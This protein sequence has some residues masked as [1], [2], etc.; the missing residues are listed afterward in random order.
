MGFNPEKVGEIAVRGTL[1][2][3]LL[4]VPGTLAKIATI[5]LRMLPRRLIVW[6]YYKLGQK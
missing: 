4:I 3:K 1:N 6:I 2:R 5:I